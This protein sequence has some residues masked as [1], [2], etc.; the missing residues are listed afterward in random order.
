MPKKRKEKKKNQKQKKKDKCTL[1]NSTILI[2]DQ[3]SVWNGLS[4]PLKELSGRNQENMTLLEGK[5]QIELTNTSVYDHYLS[6][7][8]GE[9][10]CEFL[11][12]SPTFYA[13]I[14]S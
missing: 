3:K 4:S 10:Y 7:Y 5:S 13:E 9:Y 6:A 12:C 8:M 14:L 1:K 2:F 11:F